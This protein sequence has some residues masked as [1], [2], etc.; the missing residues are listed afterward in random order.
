MDFDFSRVTAPFRMQPGLRRVA[1]GAAQLTPATPGSRHLREKMAVLGSAPQRALCTTAAFDELPVLRAIADEAARSCPET[2]IV[3]ATAAG[4]VRCE[5]PLLGWSVESDRVRGDGDA[6]IGA[7]LHG[8]APA[9]RPAA[10]LSVAFAE[11]FAVLDGTTAAVPWLAVC[12]P[13]HWAPDEKVGRAFAEVHAPVADG[14]LL[15][16]ASASLARLVTGDDRWERFVWTITADPRLD[17]H[18]ARSHVAWPE[19]KGDDD[20]ADPGRLA[21]TASLRSERQTFIPIPASGGAVF[22]ILVESVP[23]LAAVASADAA[24]RLHDAIASMSPAVLAY[25]RLAG[26]RDRLLRWLAARSGELSPSP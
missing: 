22:T 20:D 24:R 14:E 21:A 10:L 25:R 3:A 1:P 15:R 8:L 4:R 7:L 2:F 17:Q 19:A 11:D 23:L 9:L 12:L 16:A 5:A 26:A 13:S 6:A 18:P